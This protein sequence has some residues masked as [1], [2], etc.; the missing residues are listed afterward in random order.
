M[1]L[2][3]ECL[4]AVGV[5][6]RLDA[7]SDFNGDAVL[8][9][10]NLA[11]GY[12]KDFVVAS[13]TPL[14]QRLTP[15]AAVHDSEEEVAAFVSLLATEHPVTGDPIGSAAEDT[16][17]AGSGGGLVLVPNTSASTWRVGEA[18]TARSVATP[19]KVYSR[20]R[21]S[22][23]HI[24]LSSP[25]ATVAPTPALSPP[26]QL[27]ELRKPIECLLPRLWCGD[28][29]TRCLPLVLSR[30]GTGGWPALLPVRRVR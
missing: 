10:S 21:R 15:P 22:P 9:S 2:Q 8:D 3:S 17:G 20:R 11:I 25:P 6:M 4:A 13:V 30:A 1:E 28:V 24:G 27:Q 29:G 14:E 7:V 5:G 19:L 12:S 16:G 26:P 23:D 18:V